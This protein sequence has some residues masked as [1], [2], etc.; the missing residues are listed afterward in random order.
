MSYLLHGLR[1][2][3]PVP[4]RA[5]ELLTIGGRWGM[6][7][8]E[9]RT[10]WMHQPFPFPTA[11]GALLTKSGQLFLPALLN[12]VNNMVRCG[13]VML[14]GAEISTSHWMV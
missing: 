1:F 4:S 13:D 6:E 3:L 8:G 2:A 12:S 5:Q 9:Q 11:E 7:F 14:D 10:P